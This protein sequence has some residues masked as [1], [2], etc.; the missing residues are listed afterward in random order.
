MGAP[1]GRRR[2]RS[3]R[4]TAPQYPVLS[5]SPALP[6]RSSGGLPETESPCA[7]HTTLP[8]TGAWV[9]PIEDS[10]KPPPQRI[11]L[12]LPTLN[13]ARRTFF[14][15]TGAGKAEALKSVLGAGA[16]HESRAPLPARLVR[17]AAGELVWFV[18]E[19]AAV[20]VGTV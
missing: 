5:L 9:A 19:A 12:T 20:E 7:G 10:P 11:T 15:C 4:S 17:P 3:H 2:G 18:D 8:L 13:A 16:E 1:P 14:V 6:L